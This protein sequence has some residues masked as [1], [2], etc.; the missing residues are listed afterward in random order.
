MAFEAIDA[1]SEWDSESEA[2]EANRPIRK[3]TSQPSF[4]P[5]PAANAPQYVTQVQLETSLTRVDG[6]VKTVADGIST[7]N[8]RITSLSASLKKEAED[9]KKTGEGQNK[10][11]NQKMQMLALL[12]LL[13]PQSSATLNAATP[14]QDANGNPITAVATP[15][16][17]GSLDTLLPLLMVSG[18]GGSGGL[19]FGGDSSGGDGSMMMLALVL[20]LSNK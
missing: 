10:D 8:S 14:L 1:F 18:M 13:I 7:L 3:P 15:D 20:A 2:A 17:N 4:K 9:R 16:P 5:R 12:P 6:K 19:G 11:L